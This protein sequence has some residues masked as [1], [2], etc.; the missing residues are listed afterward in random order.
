MDARAREEDGFLMVELV[1]A[2]VILSIALLAL[3]AGYSAAFLSL[4]KAA[5]KSA[6]ATL[7]D[8]QLELYSALAYASIGLDATT[9]TSVKSSNSTYV[10]DEAGL[11]SAAS[12]TDHT[13]SGC[14]STSQC[15]PVQT[16]TGSDGK[17]YTIE[18]FIRD[19]ANASY[20]GR[21]E[22]VVTVLVRDPSTT[23]SPTVTQL[24]AAYDAG[25]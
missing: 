7:A 2:V 3:M 23:G 5:Q 1:A 6:G 9:L 11:T 24:S 10:S 4:H 20:T 21:S 25:P 17:S 15:L 19:I 14:G 12:A 22:R 18:T 13:I 8:N 16:L